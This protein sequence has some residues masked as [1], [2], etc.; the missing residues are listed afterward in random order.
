MKTII[1]PAISQNGLTDKHADDHTDG[2]AVSEDDE[3]ASRQGQMR[4]YTFTYQITETGAV[5]GV[6]NDTDNPKTVQFK[7]TDDGNG[8]FTVERI[9][10]TDLAFQFT[11]TYSVDPKPSR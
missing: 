5:S 11:N 10:G 4:T 6:T 9:G 2:N 7:L 8:H 3:P 1:L